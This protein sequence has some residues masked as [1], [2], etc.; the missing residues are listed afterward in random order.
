VAQSKL[1]ILLGSLRRQPRYLMMR[2][3]ARFSFV[4]GMVPLCYGVWQRRRLN[5]LL[6][7][8]VDEKDQ[9]IFK[10]IDGDRLVADLSRDGVAFGLRLPDDVVSRLRQFADQADCYAD[11]DATKGFPLRKRAAAE[12]AL[13]KPVLV[14]QYL[15]TLAA[16]PDIGKL[17]S[18]PV[19]KKI[20][21]LYL[22]GIP[23]FVGVNMW[24]TFPV[25]ASREERDRHAHFFHRDVDDFRFFKFFFYLTDVVDGDGAHVCVLKS[26]GKPP[27]RSFLDRWNLR[28]YTDQ[29]VAATY[30][31][32]QIKV[33][34]GEAGT[35]F[36]EDTWCLHKGST[37]TST[38]RLLLQLQFALNDYG[39]M[40]D[41]RDA[42]RLKNIA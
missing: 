4:R 41:V 36:V 19:L 9:S 27:V 26:Q 35:G 22:K 24:W 29:E 5:A 21:C 40:H 15:N 8:L 11:R 3:L 12:K 7:Q 6:D 16:C 18:D 17:A 10:D 33:I 37:P 25:D 1:A 31:G 20:A 13:G 42:A 32:E 28:R 2:G 30:P 14:A 23:R 34:Q 38:P 39:V